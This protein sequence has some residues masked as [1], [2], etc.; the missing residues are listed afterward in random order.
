MFTKV[1]DIF[2]AYVDK[3]SERQVQKFNELFRNQQD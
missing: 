3:V 1:K 2:Q